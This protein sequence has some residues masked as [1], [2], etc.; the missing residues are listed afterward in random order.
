MIYLKIGAFVITIFLTS[1][2][3]HKVDDA[4]YSKKVIL[5]QQ[6]D[7]EHEAA[8][9][10]AQSKI[11]QI[12]QGERDEIQ[13]RYDSLINQLNGVRKQYNAELS[14]KYPPIAIPAKG[15]ALHAKDAGFLIAFA[16]DCEITELE[17]N[18]VIDK[19]N[20]LGAG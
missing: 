3:T 7:M 1:F 11:S 5:Q 14:K 20:A 12:K 17:R 4:K 6:Q 8:V 2:I 18:E 16:R 10:N 15:L 19:Y 13:H 9:V